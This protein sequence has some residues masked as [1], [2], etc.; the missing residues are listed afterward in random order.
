VADLYRRH[1]NDHLFVRGDRELEYQAAAQVI[2]V[3]R[4]AGWER[5]G[6]MTR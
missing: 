2:D 5:I 3:A 6:L 1:L 4:G